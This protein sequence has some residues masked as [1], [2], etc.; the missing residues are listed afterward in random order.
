M[1]E[2]ILADGTRIPGA[3]GFDGEESLWIWTKEGDIVSLFALF[4]DPGKTKTIS[5]SINEKVDQT[6]EG[7]TRLTDLKVRA[8]GEISIRMKLP[9]N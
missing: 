9:K 1:E 7:Y 3:G 4:T 2:I 5:H 8:D 6:W